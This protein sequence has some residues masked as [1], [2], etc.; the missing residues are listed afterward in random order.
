VNLHIAID[1][2]QSPP[3]VTLSIGDDHWHLS[4]WKVGADKGVRHARTGGGE[5]VTLAIWADG[6][7]RN[8][9]LCVGTTEYLISNV[10]FGADGITGNAGL[11]PPDP[12]MEA[13]VARM[14]RAV[15]A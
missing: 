12:W 3:L 15:S 10:A 6:D 11:L 4:G 5:L 1:R 2:A 7:N 13:F 14:T 9:S 8:G